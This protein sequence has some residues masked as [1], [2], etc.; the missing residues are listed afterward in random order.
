M[1][2]FMSKAEVEKMRT[3]T[4]VANPARDQKT[5]GEEWLASYLSGSLSDAKRVVIESQLEVSPSVRSAVKS[6][7]AVAGS[8]LENGT[9]NEISAEFMP[10][11]WD[12]IERFGAGDFAQDSESDKTGHH[13][14]G[15]DNQRDGISAPTDEPWL[16][17]AIKRALLDFKAPLNWKFAGIGI[18]QAR[19]ASFDNGEAL[20]LL[21]A[22]G[23]TSMPVHSHRGEEWTLVLQ[24]CYRASG[25]VFGPGDLH[26]ED[27]ECEHQPIIDDG[28]ECICL[29]AI[30]GKLKFANPV[31]RLAQPFFGV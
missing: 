28:E 17:S 15:I 5:V 10:R 7:E 1:V 16:T 23:G 29:V 18:K 11:L 6:L 12:R 3:V 31:L 19:I 22:K 14:Q 26:R 25:D 20:Y 24:G 21:K 13:M 4:S 9:V 27:D 8:V 2:M 30:E